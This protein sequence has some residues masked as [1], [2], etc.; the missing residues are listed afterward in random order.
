MSSPHLAI[1]IVGPCFSNLIFHCPLAHSSPAT[2]FK[3]PQ[4]CSCLRAFALLPARAFP[5][6][7]SPTGSI[8]SS[9]SQL[10]CHLLR[11][12]LLDLP[13]QPHPF[14]M[15]SQAFHFLYKSPSECPCAFIYVYCLS[16]GSQLLQGRSLFVGSFPCL[17]SRPDPGT[18]QM[19]VNLCRRNSSVGL[20]LHVSIAIISYMKIP[21]RITGPP[22]KGSGADV[23]TD[24]LSRGTKPPSLAEGC[25]GS[26]EQGWVG[27]HPPAS[28]LPLPQP[29]RNQEAAQVK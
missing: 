24:S 21:H 16:P 15:S 18:Y 19:P 13:K 2:F 3:K 17:V 11:E 28:L 10:K 25:G 23:N 14:P 1:H 27:P 8:S 4:A 9:R 22:S 29:I 5:T 26:W 20:C 6:V 7:L 12:A